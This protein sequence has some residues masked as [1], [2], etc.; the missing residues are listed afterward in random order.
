M[1]NEQA[2][3]YQGLVSSG[4][5]QSNTPPSGFDP[6]T[7][8]RV[9]FN[10]QWW[11]KEGATVPQQNTQK[12][13]TPVGDIN[14]YVGVYQTD[15]S[16]F[17]KGRVKNNNGK[18]TLDF[19]LPKVGDIL[20]ELVFVSNNNFKLKK[21]V[22]TVTFIPNEDNSGDISSL[23]FSIKFGG[24]VNIEKT[25]VKV[26][27]DPD[28]NVPTDSTNQTKPEPT[29]PDIK[30]VDTN[31]TPTKTDNSDKTIVTKY[32]PVINKHEALN[33]KDCSSFPFT[34]GC[35]N[36]RIGRLNQIFFGDP[37]DNVYDRNLYKA[38][39]STGYFG[40]SG[41]KDGEISQTLYD[42]AM[43]NSKQQNESLDKKTIIKE[44]V[45][46]V[47]KDYIIKK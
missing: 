29:N 12:T 25:A 28:A 47:L 43:K 37:L 24:L 7:W 34:M 35:I 20:D 44:S 18:L 13:E 22:G 21:G 14:Q 9:R 33:T 41:E 17:V 2:Q 6:K 10:K 27:I 32:D 11:Y 45:K 23:K 5:K 8:T 40:M 3:T 19:K 36:P 46:K 39:Y 16:P 26:D 42:S 30:K 15:S 4:F 31:N 38:L 1:I